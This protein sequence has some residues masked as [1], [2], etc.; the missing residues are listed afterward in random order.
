MAQPI[1]EAVRGFG[2]LLRGAGMVARRPHLL[3]LGLI[4]PLL[5]TVVFVTLV[6]TTAWQAPAAAVWLT[7]F[8]EDWPAAET[9][10]SLVA[11]GLVLVV[12]LLL[13]LLFTATTLALGAPLYDRISASVDAAEGDFVHAPEVPGWQTVVDSARRL[14]GVVVVSVPAG[15]VLLLV[16]LI[17]GL[18]APLAA[19]GSAVFGG[20]MIALELVGGPAERR[21][22]RTLAAR[23]ALLRRRPWL[24]LGF[25]VPV[26]V[27]MTIPLVS[28]VAFPI[29][30]AGGTLLA[31]RLADEPVVRTP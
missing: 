2:L 19:V 3:G 17:P 20:W 25:G 8:V 7:P 31:R 16:G 23:Q 12:G 26:F 24:T 4:P 9:I 11:A 15:L 22:I 6:V 29:A 13:V 30:T 27:L 21:G 5:T 28:L 14:F 18:G 10:R 1:A